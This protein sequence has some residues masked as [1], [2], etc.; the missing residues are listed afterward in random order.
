[1]HRNC[2]EKDCGKRVTAQM[3]KSI[4]NRQCVNRVLAIDYTSEAKTEADNAFSGLRC[5]KT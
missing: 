5:I 1:M 2:K 4:Q 3:R